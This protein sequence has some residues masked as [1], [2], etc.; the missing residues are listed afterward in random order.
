M[1]R[2]RVGAARVEQRRVRGANPEARIRFANPSLLDS[3]K[4]AAA[5]VFYMLLVAL[6][7]TSNIVERLFSVAHAVLRHERH[8]LSPMMLEMILFLKMNAPR[9]DVVTVE[10]CL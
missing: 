5:P 10:Q 6:P 9:W 7:P 4:V 2:F 3:R 8:S 1:Q